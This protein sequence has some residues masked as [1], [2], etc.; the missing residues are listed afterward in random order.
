MSQ[1][2]D[3]DDS[4]ELMCWKE[5]FDKYLKNTCENDSK[6]HTPAAP[7]NYLMSQEVFQ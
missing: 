2:A 4:V 3:S 5:T 6:V 7:S 1:P